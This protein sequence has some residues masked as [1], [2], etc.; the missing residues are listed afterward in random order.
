MTPLDEKIARGCLLA[1]A[2]TVKALAASHPDGARLRKAFAY[3]SEQMIAS[4]LA[5]ETDEQILGATRLWLE[6]FERH[7]PKE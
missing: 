7:I 3:V 1:C 2:T 5:T 6:D 4:L